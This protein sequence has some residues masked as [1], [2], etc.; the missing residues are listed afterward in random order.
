MKPS[1]GRRGVVMD[2]LGIASGT[3]PFAPQQ[4]NPSP[5]NGS[6]LGLQ[7]RGTVMVFIIIYGFMIYQL[8][9]QFVSQTEKELLKHLDNGNNGKRSGRT[10]QSG[11]SHGIKS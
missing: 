4:G 2:A 9:D 8:W 1:G 11:I 5:Q 10:P 6:T 7:T 3:S